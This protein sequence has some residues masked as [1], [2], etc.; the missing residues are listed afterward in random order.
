MKRFFATTILS[1][2]AAV[3]VGSFA[4]AV[5]TAPQQGNP[6]TGQALEIGPPVIDLRADPGQVLKT[7]INI[8]DVSTS[9]LVV[10]GTVD[11]FAANGED[12][13]PRVLVD[14]KEPSPYSIRSWIAPLNKLTLKPKEVQNLPV[15]ITVPKNA[16]PGG[17]YGVIRFTGTPPDIE[18]T[19][20][21]LSASLGSLVFI[22]VNGDAKEEMALKS[23]TTA[24]ENGDTS[25][26]ESQPI[27]FV[28]RIEN[29]GNVHEQPVGRITV[30]DMFGNIVAGVNVNLERR[31]VLPGSIRKFEQTLDKTNIGDRFLFGLYHAEVVMTYGNNQTTTMSTSF[32]VLPWRAIIGVIVLL[33][34]VII[35]GR[36]ALKRHNERLVGRSRGSRRH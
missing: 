2:I 25:L 7:T 13:T 30:K 28:E 10:T 17:Y 11:D 33:V 4:Y 19:G 18:G 20:V 5:T 8:R 16:A 9:P 34:I 29:K 6:G 31:N 35:A 27:T 12:G 23:F 22:R 26:F 36:I 1:V 14:N 15:T 3:T 24:G 21:S 32:W